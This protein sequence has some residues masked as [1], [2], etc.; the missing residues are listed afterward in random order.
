MGVVT[1]KLILPLF[2]L[3]NFTSK[4]EQSQGFDPKKK[5]DFF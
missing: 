3:F 2:P 1:A 5:G 4:N